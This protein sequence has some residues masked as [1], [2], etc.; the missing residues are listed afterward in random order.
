MDTFEKISVDSVIDA[1]D[2][3]TKAFYIADVAMTN[4][5]LTYGSEE[6]LAALKEAGVNVLQVSDET[7]YNILRQLDTLGEDKRYVVALATDLKWM[8]GIDYRS[9]SLP[10]TL[11][12]AKSFPSKR[13]ALQGFNRAGRFNDKCLRARFTDTS[14]L[15][16][17]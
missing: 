14:I 9:K 2:N 8:R 16:L 12:I 6:L 7:D 3:K 4:P 17:V 10:L 5:V 1:S 15:D 11:I 13:D